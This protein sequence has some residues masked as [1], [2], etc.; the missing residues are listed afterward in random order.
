MGFVRHRHID[1]G[2]HHEY[3][4]LQRHDQYADLSVVDSPYISLSR[5]SEQATLSVNLERW[6]SLG[7]GYF[8]VR[9]ADDSRTRLL[10]LSWSKPLW[11]NTS[12]Y[13]SANR[14]VGDSDWAM[15]A[16][17]V[18][19]FDLHGSLALSAERDTS[20][21]TRQ[22]VNYSRAVPTQGG[23]GYNLGYA[24]DLETSGIMSLERV[25]KF[26]YFFF[27]SQRDPRE[28]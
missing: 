24:D 19:P 27:R 25:P 10:N 1:N 16:Q 15:Q 6:G 2:E 22:R 12:F 8:D 17:L 20:G 5:R 21:Q 7:A 14:E 28:V 18:I 23:L 11:R 3:V 13:L 4:R 9:A 26:S